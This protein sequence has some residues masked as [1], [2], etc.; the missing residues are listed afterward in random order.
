MQMGV[1]VDKI[2]SSFDAKTEEIKGRSAITAG[3]VA[4]KAGYG[5]LLSRKENTS[6]VAVNKLLKEGENVS[7]AEANFSAGKQNYEPGAFIIEKGANTESRIK[8]LAKELGVDFFSLDAKPGASLRKLKPVRVG[9]YKSWVENMDEGWTRWF[10]EQHAFAVD[11]L[12]DKDLL[13]RDLSAYHAIIIPDQEAH[14]ILNGHASGTMPE[15]YVGGIGLEGSLALKKYVHQGGS[16]ITFD[17]ASDFAID[18]FGLP[19]KNVVAGLTS[20][21]FFIPGS[22]IRTQVNIKHPLAYGMQPEVAASFNNS[23]AFE[24]VKK[25]REGEGGKEETKL[26]PEPPVEIIASYAKK[27]LLMSGW[28][29]NEDKYIAGKAAVVRVKQGNGNIVLFAFRPQF[30]GQP[31]GTYKLIFNAIYG[32]PAEKAA[33]AGAD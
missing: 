19:L 12:H 8:A 17:G 31:R 29:L 4:N 27:D 1:K 30:R 25:V 33:Q 15:P 22:L 6:I 11:T 13:N 5:Y 24:V 23:R 16:L 21:Q 9:L 20:Q 28:A 2:K 3:Q 7:V 18:Q 10:M 14:E 26:G 32:A